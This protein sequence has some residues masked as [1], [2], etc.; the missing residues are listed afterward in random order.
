MSDNLRDVVLSVAPLPDTFQLRL[1]VSINQIDADMV[2][3]NV[4]PLLNFFAAASA[5]EAAY[6]TLQIRYSAFITRDTY[7]FLRDK[8]KHPVDDAL[9]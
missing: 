1:S 9:A 4:V 6:R 5:D 3:R 8:V 2:V 7:T